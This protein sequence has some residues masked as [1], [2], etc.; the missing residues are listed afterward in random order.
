MNTTRRHSPA[1]SETVQHP[2][3]LT[4]SAARPRVSQMGSPLDIAVRWQASAVARRLRQADAS[5][6]SQRRRW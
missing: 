3:S 4:A 5:G 1:K 6:D 2:N